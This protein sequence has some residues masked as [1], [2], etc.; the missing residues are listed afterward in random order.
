MWFVGSNRAARNLRRRFG[1]NELCKSWDN[2]R[3][4][5]SWPTATAC[6]RGMPTGAHAKWKAWGDWL[7]CH[8]FEWVPS[9]IHSLGSREQTTLHRL[10]LSL[11]TLCWNHWLITN[12]AG[13]REIPWRPRK[14]KTNIKP[15]QKSQLSA[16]KQVFHFE[17]RLVHL[18]KE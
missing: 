16:E 9:P 12:Y 5:H 4:L 18:I 15:E 7:I 3:S 8:K 11:Y 6:V 10:K 1:S 14:K 13:T 17:S 2:V